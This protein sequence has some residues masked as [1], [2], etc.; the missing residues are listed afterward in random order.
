MGSAWLVVAALILP[1]SGPSGCGGLC[2]R[3]GGTP[4][5]PRAQPG[6]GVHPSRCWEQG[7]REER[8]WGSSGRAGEH[9]DWTR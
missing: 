3:G 1:G 4:Q 7:G 9:Q 2:W 6:L 5:H 8:T